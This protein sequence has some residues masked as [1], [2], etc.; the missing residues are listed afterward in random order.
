[1][2]GDL[3]DIRPQWM[4][5]YTVK[6]CNVEMYCSYT[7]NVVL[8]SI[9]VLVFGLAIYISMALIISNMHHK[10]R[11][12]HVSLEQLCANHQIMH[13]AQRWVWKP[14]LWLIIDHQWCPDLSECQYTCTHNQ[15]MEIAGFFFKTALSRFSC[16]LS[17]RLSLLMLMHF[18]FH[19]KMIFILVYIGFREARMFSTKCGFPL[20]FHYIYWKRDDFGGFYKWGCPDIWTDKRV[21]QLLDLCN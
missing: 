6:Q 8:I 17:Q 21:K 12:L 20:L 11:F 13:N 2:K 5:L 7:R 15:W 19:F 4:R 14:C 1:M 18:P 10:T 9:R 16:N 3:S